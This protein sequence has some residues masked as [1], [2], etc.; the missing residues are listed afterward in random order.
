M[1]IEDFSTER[2][3]GHNMKEKI[4][5][6]GKIGESAA[7]E[8]QIEQVLDKMEKEWELLTCKFQRTKRQVQVC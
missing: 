8:Y 6:I 4:D 1:P 2:V 5:V 7:K 3:L